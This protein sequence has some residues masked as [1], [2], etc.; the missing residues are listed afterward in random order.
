MLQFTMAT[1]NILRQRGLDEVRATYQR[2]NQLRKID[3]FRF[4]FPRRRAAATEEEETREEGAAVGADL[5][6]R[7]S[8]LG[9]WC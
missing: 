8:R 3:I 7:F 4:R 2:W 1:P 9:V 5:A 6:S